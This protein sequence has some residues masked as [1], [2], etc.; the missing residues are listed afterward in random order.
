MNE[1]QKLATQ[2][3]GLVKQAKGLHDLASHREWTPEESAK[4]DDIVAQIQALDTRLTSAEEAIAAD[5]A[6]DVM[7]DMPEP[8]STAAPVPDPT[9][10]N[11]LSRRIEKLEGLL[12]SNRRTA[13]AP[14]GSPAFVRDLDDRR[15]ESDR[16]S[17]LQGWCLGREATAQHRSA[18][19]RTGLDLNNDRLVLKRSAQSTT[20]GAGGY[21]IPQ[22]FLAELEKKLLYFNNLRNVS[23]VIRT[24]TGNPLPFPVTDDTGNPATVGAENTA[25]SE[26]ALTFTQVLLGSYRYE[27]LVLTSNELLR[28]SGLDLASEIGGMLGERIGRKETTDFTTGNGTTAPEGVVTGSSAGVTGA[29]TTT[30]TLANIMGLIGSLDYAYQQGASFM[31]H[32]AI[33]NT[34]L[35]LADSQSRPLFLDLLNGNAPKLLGYPVV[36]NNAMASSIAASAK[37]ILFGDFSKHMIRDIGDIEIIR[38]NERYADKYQTGFL[39]INRCDAKVMQSSAIKRIT[40][41]AS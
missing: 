23:R 41:P 32:Q 6:E 30:I 36:I 13:P 2:R 31:M 27:S 33:W 24:D 3:A 40:Q 26:T 19:Q 34:I 10:Q 18:A 25:P 38:L 8:D 5:P 20:S 35:Q 37:T 15:L 12:V 7:A 39:A 9:Q 28:D 14:L 29:T 22:G 11:N 21:T 17:A 16:R 1:R 4:V